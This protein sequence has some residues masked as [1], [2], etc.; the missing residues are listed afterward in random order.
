MLATE[1]TVN[2][3][4]IPTIYIGRTRTHNTRK[5]VFDF[6]ALV[7][8]FGQGDF[9][10]LYSR[11]EEPTNRPEEEMIVPV[12]ISGCKAVWT[13]SD[14]DT[15]TTGQGAAEIFYR[16]DSFCYKTNV[17]PIAVNHAIG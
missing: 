14:D 2:R 13:I 12:E 5:I 17:F 11:P 10:L 16:N 6:S 15:A 8:E 1:I 9:I 7:E 3:S 4:D